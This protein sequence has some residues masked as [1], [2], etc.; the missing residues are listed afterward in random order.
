MREYLLEPLNMN[1][2]ILIKKKKISH[3][4]YSLN[5]CTTK[6]ILNFISIIFDDPKSRKTFKTNDSSNGNINHQKHDSKSNLGD[7]FK[8]K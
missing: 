5:K 1:Q 8:I 4:L 2:N 3:I 7:S 6:S